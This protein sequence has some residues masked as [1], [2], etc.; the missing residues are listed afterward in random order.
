MRLSPRLDSLRCDATSCTTSRADCLPAVAAEAP[1]HRQ[2]AG[3]CSL[4]TQLAAHRESGYAA[5]Q[6]TMMCARET[7]KGRRRESV[8]ARTGAPLLRQ[9]SRRPTACRADARCM[10]RFAPTPSL[11]PPVMDLRHPRQL[12]PSRSQC[13]CPFNAGVC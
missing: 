7:N 11:Q 12:N 3:A 13:K 8:M 10:M 6:E 9:A 2:Y 1:A 4:T 5:C